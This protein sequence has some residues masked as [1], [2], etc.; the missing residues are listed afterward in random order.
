VQPESLRV[1]KAILPAGG[2]GTRLRPLTHLMPKELLPVGG[3]VVL[4]YV[5]EECQ[6]A[7]ITELLVVSNRRKL[8]LVDACEALPTEQDLLTQVPRRTI[9]FANQEEQ[10]GL[11]HAILHGETFAGDDPF[12]VALAD[13]IIDGPEGA[14]LRRMVAAHGEH[15]AAATIA[16]EQVDSRRVSRYGIL[17]PDGQ[18]GETFRVRGIVEKP[19]P[20]TAPSRHAISA[21]YVF[22]PEIFAACRAVAQGAGR[23]IQLTDAMTWLARAGRPVVAVCLHPDERRLDIGNQ[24]SYFAAFALKAGRPRPP[25]DPET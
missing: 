20:E 19:A 13:T 17:E 3:R 12:V 10:L 11:A 8:G 22:T 1:R 25:G 24:E 4:Q 5:L 21:R 15:G 18:T 2:M 6:A 16:A 9:Y 23:E 7:G 14:L